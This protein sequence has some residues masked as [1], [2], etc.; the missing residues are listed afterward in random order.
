MS[1]SS[2]DLKKTNTGKSLQTVKKRDLCYIPA[3]DGVRVIAIL[4]VLV[5]HYLP[6][7]YFIKKV[8][9]MGR[10]GVVLFFVLSGF[11]ITRILL[12]AKERASL[13]KTPSL[14]IVRNF[15]I[16]RFLRI[17]PAYYAFILVAAIL[18]GDVRQ[19][20]LWYI[21]YSA[22]YMYWVNLKMS[23]VL[24]HIW[25][26]CVEEQFYLFWP[27][28]I[29][30][31]PL[32]K[33]VRVMIILIA[34]SFCFKMYGTWNMMDGYMIYNSLPG[35]LDHLVTGALFAVFYSYYKSNRLASGLFHLL[36]ISGSLMFVIFN[37]LPHMGIGGHTFNVINGSLGELSSSLAFVYFIY[38]VIERKACIHII[39]NLKAIRYTGKVTYGLYLYHLVAISAFRYFFPV[40]DSGLNSTQHFFL[41]C[42]FSLFLAIVSWELYEKPINN[43]KKY[44]LYQ[45]SGNGRV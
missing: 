36:G 20:I 18:S 4:G 19:H 24:F 2:T 35:N 25:S 31:L 6:D 45:K 10:L 9:P 40:F 23:G 38:I 32:T 43:L 27:F 17:F 28:V 1:Q 33:A 41:Y 30:F 34:A 13:D 5:W 37:I 22:N 11:L 29:I 21:T 8:A 44:F 14:W 26:L 16:R 12:D 15:Y 39:L 42:V 7:Y 3:L